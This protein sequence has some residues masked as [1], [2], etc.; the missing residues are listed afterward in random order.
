MGQALSGQKPPATAALLQPA[1][2]GDLDSIKSAV[3][4]YKQSLESGS[5]RGAIEEAVSVYVN[6]QDTAGNAA[7]HGAC[8]GG[9]TEV[10]KYLYEGAACSLFLSNEIGCNAVFLAAGYGHVGLLEYLLKAIQTEESRTG[11]SVRSQTVACNSTGD[12]ALIAAAS[13]GHTKVVDLLLSSLKGD[14]EL[15][16]VLNSR[17]K[18]GDTPLSVAVAAGHHETVALIAEQPGILID[19]INNTQLT[20]LLVA[21]E[22]GQVDILKTLLSA[23]ADCTLVDA[24]G[25][26]PLMIGVFCGHESVLCEL[27]QWSKTHES[28]TET[29][30]AGGDSVGRDHQVDL[31]NKPDAQSVS[32]LWIAAKNGNLSMV[33]ALVAAGADV[34]H[35]S[36]DGTKALDI[37]RKQG[38]ADIVEYLESQA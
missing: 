32:P 27:L 15:S 3:L 18:G 38:K 21:C 5:T 8:F 29:A 19:S 20:P 13:R 14:L 36:A 6:R 11:M 34:A 12:N 7:L 25:A 4:T 9:H 33:K 23:N 17:N 10:V 31:V 2:T 1:V 24:N 16:S 22:R 37:A 30:D 35:I 26:S 28:A